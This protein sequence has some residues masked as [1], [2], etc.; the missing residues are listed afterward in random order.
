MFFSLNRIARFVLA[1]G[2]GGEDNE[3]LYHPLAAMQLE[4]LT[5][6]VSTE[7]DNGW[8]RVLEKM[9]DA[10]NYMPE[11]PSTLRAE[12]RVYQREGFEWLARLAHWYEVLHADGFAPVQQAWLAHAQPAGSQMSGTRLTIL[13]PSSMSRFAP[14]K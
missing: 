3:L 2:D 6:Q 13:L 11:L 12:L 10:Q 1:D 4:K 14:R 5:S 8:S 7:T 9:R